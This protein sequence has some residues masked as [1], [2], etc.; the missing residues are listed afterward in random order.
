M[1]GRYLI[2]GSQIGI[3]KTFVKERKARDVLDEI[4]EDQ[5][6]GNSKETLHS[7]KSRLSGM[8]KE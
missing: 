7:D 2:S 8:F 3:L 5:F 1:G 4:F 6:L